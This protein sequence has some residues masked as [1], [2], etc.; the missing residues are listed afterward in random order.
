MQREDAS[1]TGWQTKWSGALIQI[2]I[3]NGWYC[4]HWFCRT[5]PLPPSTSPRL[6]E[7]A[8]HLVHE[9]VFS[10][11][12]G[13]T[14]GRCLAQ[15]VR[16]PLCR[17]FNFR[18][19]DGT[20]GLHPESPSWMTPNITE[21]WLYVTLSPCNHRRPWRPMRPIDD[22]WRWIVTD[23]LSARSDIVRFSERFPCH[24]F[25]KGL[26][27]PSWWGRGLIEG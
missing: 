5:L 20:C 13:F 23:D 11:I 8:D 4:V 14:R 15:C 19:A 18:S 24:I 12:S 6:G 26:Y 2:W 16:Q 1:E 21:G 17:A 3:W 25:H 22:G 7:I 9:E 10:V 27:L